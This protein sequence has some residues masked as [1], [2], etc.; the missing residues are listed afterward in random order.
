MDVLVGSQRY[1][2]SMSKKIRFIMTIVNLL[3]LFVITNNA[4]EV[5]EVFDKILAMN[6]WAWRDKVSP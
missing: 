6:L 1:V 5:R 2:L 4:C 3:E